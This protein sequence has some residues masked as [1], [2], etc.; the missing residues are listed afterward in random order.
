MGVAGVV[1][2]GG[3]GG[4]SGKPREPIPTNA[5]NKTGSGSSTKLLRGAG[6]ANPPTLD[7]HCLH[8]FLTQ[9]SDCSNKSSSM[10]T[11]WSMSR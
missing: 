6:D 10:R 9:G 8:T 5:D 11:S 4:A 2:V 7:N 1:V 3:G